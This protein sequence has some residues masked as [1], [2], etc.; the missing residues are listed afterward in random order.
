MN[1]VCLVIGAI[2][3]ILCNGLPRTCAQPPVTSL[4]FAPSGDRLVAASQTGITVYSWPELE[5]LQRQTCSAGNLHDLAF[6]PDGSQLAAAGGDPA[7]QGMVELFSWPSLDSLQLCR[8]HEDSV[9]AV[10]WLDDQ[11]LASASLDH[12]IIVWDIESRSERLR[13]TGHSRGVS[14]LTSLDGR[15]LV[16]AG[17]DHQ[18]RVWDLDSGELLRSLNNHTQRVHAAVQRPASPGLP[19]VASLSDD[20]SVRFWQ[21]TIGRMVR[22]ARLDVRPLDCCW[23]PD[24]S[25]LAVA[26]E[27]GAVRWIDPESAA[28]SEKSPGLDGWAFSIAIAPDASA[29]VI[30]GRGGKLISLPRPSASPTMP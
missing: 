6:S 28:V 18:L 3:A 5:T 4:A 13:L 30:G 21:P 7:E 29:V 14:D 15:I 20:R 10:I 23:L 24:G 17:L 2:V 12:D 1:K 9:L 16:S 11:R 19:M 22:F 26:C 25:L 27:D 8:G